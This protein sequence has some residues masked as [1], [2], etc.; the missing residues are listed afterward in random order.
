VNRKRLGTLL[1]SVGTLAV[2]FAMFFPI[3]WM[4]LTSLK[5]ENA[6]IAFP[7]QW[8]FVP[9]FENWRV[10]VLG[11]PVLEFMGNTALIT[12][13]STLLALALGI[14]A[15][16][17]MAF[18]RTRRTDGSML[19][20]MSTRMLPPAGVIVPLFV[21]FRDLSLLDTHLGLILLFAGMNLPLVVWMVT[22][23]MEDVPFAL[24][25]AARLDGANLLQEFTRV[26]L[27][28]LLPGL[29]ATALLALIFT[30]NEFFFAVNLTTRTASPLSVYVS[31]FK[32]AQGDLFIAKMSAA[33]TASVIPVL[34]A[35]WLAQRQLVTG[36]TMGAV[37]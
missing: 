29:A 24:I 7:P 3:L 11:G 16:Y 15:A 4:V 19:W 2:A 20:M 36:L 18:Y 10:A 37:K 1:W 13:L 30:W 35:G 25:E 23:F 17:A 8:F 6:A 34:I 26:L 27:P 21:L 5:T 32:A 14:P 33:A 22:G 31:T 28:L 9:T 12:V